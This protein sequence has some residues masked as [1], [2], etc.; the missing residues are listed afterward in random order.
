MRIAAWLAAM[1]AFA[2]VVSV[3]LT[4]SPWGFLAWL[5]A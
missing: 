4:K 2:Y 3:A 1:L 5:M